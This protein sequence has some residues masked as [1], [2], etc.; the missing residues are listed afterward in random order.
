MLFLCVNFPSVVGDSFRLDALKAAIL[1]VKLR[2]LNQWSEK[3]QAN[4]SHL[5]DHFSLR[6]ERCVRAAVQ[7]GYRH[8][9]NHHRV[10]VSHRDSLQVFLTKR[11]IGHEIDY[12]LP[13]CLQDIRIDIL[14][15]RFAAVCH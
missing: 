5:D 10:R 9:F 15:D 7:N 11:N 6:G 3:R 12:V 8:I 1:S 2:N 13:L 4:A 14:D